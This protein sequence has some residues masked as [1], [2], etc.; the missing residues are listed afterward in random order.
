MTTQQDTPRGV[1]P[2]KIIFANQLR[3]VAVL[4]VLI[5][6]LF[7]IYFLAPDYVS[8]TIHSPEVCA[9]RVVSVICLASASP[10]CA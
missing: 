2:S 9:R 7:G 5:N 8:E 10:N 3:A 1:E 6:H 4:F